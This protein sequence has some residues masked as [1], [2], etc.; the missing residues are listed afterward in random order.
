V[1]RGLA[2]V[3]R[4][5]ESSDQQKVAGDDSVFEEREHSHGRLVERPRVCC[6]NPNIIA[7]H[8]LPGTRDVAQKRRSSTTRSWLAMLSSRSSRESRGTMTRVSKREERD[9]DA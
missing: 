9:H 7:A 5:A 4:G 3:K 2:A 1:G 6:W 8:S